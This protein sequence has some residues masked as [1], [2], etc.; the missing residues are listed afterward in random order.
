MIQGSP[1]WFAARLGNVTPSRIIDIMPGKSGYRAA[2][3]NYIAQC[4]CERLTGARED[5]YTSPAMQWGTDTEPMARAVY[6][7]TMGV[8]V[9]EVGY[10][11]HPD[12][13]HFGGSPDGLISDDG[14][15]EVKCPNTAT[16]LDTL[17]NGTI[18]LDYLYQMHGYMIINARKW[19][20]FVSYDPRLPDKHAIY[21][22]RIT[23]D[24]GM[25]N[26]ILTE[27]NKALT[28]INEMMDK[29]TS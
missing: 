28:E 10:I 6:E 19:C 17:L 12:I 16:H 29:L 21:I 2:R 7:A 1:E 18:K 14:M 26:S 8:I 15:I 27:V 5:T 11:P 9:K 20:D 22:K 3:K 4:V 13:E 23:Y 24:I 25:A